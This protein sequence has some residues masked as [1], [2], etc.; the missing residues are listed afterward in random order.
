MPNTLAHLGLQA[1]GTKAISPRADFKWIAIGCIVPDLS[2]IVQRIIPFLWSDIS[3]LDLRVYCI[4]QASFFFCILLSAAISL[5]VNDGRK[6]FLILVLN[7]LLH[8]FL[9]ASQIKWANGVHLFAPFSW[10]LVQYGFYWPE[11]IICYSMTCLGFLLV[12]VFFVRD[13]DIIH[14]YTGNIDKRIAGVFLLLLYVF[15]PL[16]FFSGIKG[17][18]NHFVATLANDHERAGKIVE[19]DR[20]RYKPSG[21]ELEIFTGEIIQ[22][23]NRRFGLKDLV[24]SLQGRFVNNGLIEVSQYHIHS[25]LRD[26]SSLLGL[27]LVAVLWLKVFWRKFRP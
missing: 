22:I 18:D 19:F 17:A 12:V 4:I 10:Q 3:L 21:N 8:L 9:D 2:W 6:V 24:V 14:G 20:V 1:L 16:L 23:S 13:T 26:Y 25:P 5:Q 27:I 15:L 7:C 11:S